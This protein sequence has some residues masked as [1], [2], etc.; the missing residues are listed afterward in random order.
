MQ[1]RV[2]RQKE[3]KSYRECL[4]TVCLK[5]SATFNQ[6]G[7]PSKCA[8][9]NI[10]LELTSSLGNILLTCRYRDTAYQVFPGTT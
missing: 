5:G 1:E 4:R 6:W 7:M 3:N 10:E 2:D 9:H 8:T